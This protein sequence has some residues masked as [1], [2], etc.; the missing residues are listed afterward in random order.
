MITRL[1]SSK[2]LTGVLALALAGA[3]AYAV[4]VIQ[5]LERQEIALRQAQASMLEANKR[6]VE[7]L[8]RSRR[9]S[10]LNQ[11]I[12]DDDAESDCPDPAVINRAIERL[13]QRQD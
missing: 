3:G 4:H 13:Q 5:K 8:A 9:L 2:I 12:R 6:M 7:E 10:K 1:L 11:E